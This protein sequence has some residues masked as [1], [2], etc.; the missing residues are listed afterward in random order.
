MKAK[1]QFTTPMVLQ[2]VPIV[3]ERD[4]LLGASADLQVLAAGQDYFEW[5]MDVEG[6]YTGMGTYGADDWTFSD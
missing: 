3:L 6:D 1:K 5:N 2:T 4:L